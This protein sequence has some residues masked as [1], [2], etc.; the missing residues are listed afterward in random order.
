MQ[1]SKSEVESIFSIGDLVT[2]GGGKSK[3]HITSIDDNSVRIAPPGARNK[4]KLGYDKLTVVVNSFSSVD[5]NRIEHSVGKLLARH[6]LREVTTES[7]LFGFAR[8][9]LSR[10]RQ[11]SV[12]P[13]DVPT[14]D[15]L[16]LELEKEI[17]R[18]RQSSSE[19]RRER[20]RDAPKI[21]EKVAVTTTAFRRNS[22]V[23]VEVLARADG[24]CES[25]SRR[26]PFK[27]RSDGSPYLEVHHRVPLSSGGEDTVTNAIALCPNCHRAA[28]Y[29]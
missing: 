11:T 29:A 20:L 4:F 3:F 27:R 7:Y 14:L 15:D 28:H 10:K 25:C 21:P 9:Y 8:E 24:I 19:Q 2:S 22:D 1:I 13:T 16:G 17:A 26:A 5:E 6:G 23:I 12:L 18:S